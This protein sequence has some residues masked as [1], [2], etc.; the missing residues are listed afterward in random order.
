VPEL[1]DVEGRKR[2]LARFAE[3]RRICRVRVRD[4]QVL[5]G[6]TPQ[7]LGRAVHHHRFAHPERR[8]KWLLARTDGPTLV[9]HF[10]MDGELVWST[11]PE[12]AGRFDRVVFDLDGGRLTYRT[13]RKL[14]GVW[15]ARGEDQIAR[16][17]GPLGPGAETID[18]DA[19]AELL[20]GR[21]GGLKAALMD[22]SLLAGLG[23]ELTDEILWRACLHPRRAARRLDDGELDRLHRA[24][25][26][27]LRTS[28]RH[29]RIPALEGW[30]ESVRGLDEPR[31]PRC[32]TPIVRLRISGRTA[33]VCPADQPPPR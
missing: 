13:R 3:G 28:V 27:V 7:G 11:G 20:Q 22:Q 8:G 33:Y 17:T 6:T 15:V 21:R 1:P 12:T 31:C 23:N 29:G 4:D 25:S 2:Y 9:L 32:G 24:L 30:L 16:T 26:E 10:G 19:L 18:R 5:R 14:G